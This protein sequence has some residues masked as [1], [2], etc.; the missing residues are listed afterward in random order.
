MANTL[1][2][3]IPDLYAALDLV[4]REQIGLIPAVTL[5][6][7]ATRA[8]IGQVVRIPLTAAATATDAVPARL[9]PDDGDQS[10]GN[11][12]ITIN[13]SRRVPVR[14]T[15]EEQRALNTNGP[16]Y[17]AILQNQFA[18]AMRTLTNE[19]EADLAALYTKA[20]RAYGTAGTAPFATSGDY[21]DA[22]QIRKI[23]MDNGAPTSDLQLVLN[24]AAGASIRGKQAQVQMIGDSSL[25]RQ[26]VL[27][28]MHGFSIR[29]SAQI[30]NVS[31][32]TGA[33]Y[34]TTAAG[35][36][37]GATSIPLITGSGAILAGDVITFAGDTNKYLVTTGIT[38][39]GTLVI[40]APG[41]RQAI[42]AATTAVTVGNSFTA[43]L[44]FSR[45]SILLA[46]RPPALPAE[47]DAATDRTM[48][49]D[50]KSGL[51]FEV[52]MYPQYM[53]M[54]YD[55]RLAWGVACIK[56]ECLAVLLG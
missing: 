15:G 3:L 7:N 37:V 52:S 2:G 55:V 14:W 26:G 51:T 50:P 48:I 35:F 20:S 49:T 10:I 29:E 42:P 16:G 43:N 9:P 23:L 13:K 17:R 1:T 45:G 22:A 41:L 5:D 54:M 56:P 18:H 19:V 12:T 31:K 30:K 11:T 33:G 47:G 34:T 21:A 6:A 24:T 4:L 46:A 38:A 8:A 40:A 39:P 32:G 44:A 36:A 27:L 25:L 28:D 53:Q